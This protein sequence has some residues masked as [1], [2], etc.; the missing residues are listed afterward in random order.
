MD[1][2]RELIQ[3]KLEEINNLEIGIEVPD[4]LLEKNKTYFS[5]TLQKVYN[6]SDHDKNYTYTIYVNGFIKRLQNDEEN[7]LEIIDK[8]SQQIES[9][10]KELNIKSSYLDITLDNGVRKIRVDGDVKYNELNKGL[11]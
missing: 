8:I 9:K 11:Y 7:T 5:Y 4:D 10:F 3:A 2:I 6:N 1:K